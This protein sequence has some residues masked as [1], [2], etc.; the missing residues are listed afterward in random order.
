MFVLAQAAILGVVSGLVVA[1]PILAL[2]WFK[3]LRAQAT[4]ETVVDT[5]HVLEWLRERR[6]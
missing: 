3:G 5:E 6:T 1:S 2:T 4:G